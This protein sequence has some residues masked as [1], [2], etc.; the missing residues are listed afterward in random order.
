MF[1][2]YTNISSIVTYGIITE[3][4]LLLTDWLSKEYDMESIEVPPACSVLYF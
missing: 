3:D 2:L 1:M 4:Q